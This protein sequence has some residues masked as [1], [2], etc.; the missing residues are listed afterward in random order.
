LT[1]NDFTV[2][3]YDTLEPMEDPAALQDLVLITPTWSSAPWAASDRLR[4]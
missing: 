2:D 4:A 3:L 1:D